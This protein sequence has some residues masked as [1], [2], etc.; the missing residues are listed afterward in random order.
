LKSSHGEHGHPLLNEGIDKLWE[1]KVGKKGGFIYVVGRTIL[2]LD[3][4]T[5]IIIIIKT[6]SIE[7]PIPAIEYLTRPFQ[8]SY[9]SSKLE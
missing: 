5:T 4:D 8:N 7:V 2:R 1:V 9:V 6:L 3:D